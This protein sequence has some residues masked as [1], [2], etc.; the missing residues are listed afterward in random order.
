MTK[1]YCKKKTFSLITAEKIKQN[2]PL[3]GYKL[4]K[5]KSTW[6]GLIIL[7]YEKTFVNG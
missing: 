5:E 6:Y 4:I 1:K 3:K 2:M 7:T